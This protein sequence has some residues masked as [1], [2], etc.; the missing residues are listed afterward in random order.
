VNW[1]EVLFPKENKGSTVKAQ[2]SIALKEKAQQEKERARRKKLYEIAKRE[3]PESLQ[4]RALAQKIKCIENPEYGEK[5]EQQV[6][7]SK[8]KDRTAS[9]N[10]AIASG[11]VN[12]KISPEGRALIKSSYIAWK[13]SHSSMR[14]FYK[15]LHHEKHPLLKGY[16]RHRLAAFCENNKFSLLPV[17]FGQMDNAEGETSETI[18]ESGMIEDQVMPALPPLPTAV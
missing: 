15:A 7:T 11:T 6:R 18:L 17:V 10:F 12:K 8:S 5:H 2:K 14:G 1:D 3:N 9:K 4:R 16:D 13:G